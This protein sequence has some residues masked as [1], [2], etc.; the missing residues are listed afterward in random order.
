MSAGNIPLRSGY[1]IFSR[2]FFDI[3]KLPKDAVINDAE[4]TLNIDTLETVVGTNYLNGIDTYFL[5]DSINTDSISSY[6]S[7]ARDG[8]QFTGTITSFVREW[9]KGNNNGLILTTSSP[10]D[11][12][13]LFAIKGSSSANLNDRPYLKI[14]YTSKE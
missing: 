14:T 13:E 5:L 9:I 6:V 12:V 3:P 7:L 2:L 10:F 4:L 11:G 8:S 1:V